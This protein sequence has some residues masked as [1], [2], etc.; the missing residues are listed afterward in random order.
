METLK[1]N[2]LVAYRAFSKAFV[3]F[4]DEEWAIFTSGATI[5]TLKKKELFIDIGQT[6]NY[7]GFIGKG[8]VRF[9]FV[10]DG[11]E[12]TNYFCF[13]GEMMSSYNSFLRQIPSVIAIEALEPTDVVSL[14]YDAVQKLYADER[15]AHKAEIFHRKIAENLLGCYEDRVMA[16]VTLSAEERY[17]NLFMQNR[18]VMNRIP[19]HYIANYLGVTPVSLSRIRK[20][21]MER[22]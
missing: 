1:E 2:Y 15:I 9:F 14:S 5:R 16:F 6:E 13:G 22:N 20:R 21:I 11:E 12:L 4:T 3:D 10:K 8:S 7:V 19:Q 18:Q 17:E